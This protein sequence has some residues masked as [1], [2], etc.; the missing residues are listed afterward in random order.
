MNPL[1]HVSIHEIQ[2]D[3][4]ACR[5][6]CKRAHFPSRGA[7]PSRRGD[8]EGQTQLAHKHARRVSCMQKMHAWMHGQTQW[9]GMGFVIYTYKYTCI[10]THTHTQNKTKQNIHAHRHAHTQKH[11][12]VHNNFTNVSNWLLINWATRNSCTHIYIH[13]HKIGPVI[14]ILSTRTA[15]GLQFG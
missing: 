7:V 5:H 12:H 11:T 1:I 4:R 2:R 10:K 9:V 14:I 13:T 15:W 3:A 6:G 8:E